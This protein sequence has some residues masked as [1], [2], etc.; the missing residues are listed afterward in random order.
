MKSEQIEQASLKLR[1]RRMPGWYW[2]Q[3]ELIDGWAPIIG[4]FA[5]GVYHVLARHS[6]DNKVAGLSIQA[7]SS[8]LATSRDSVFRAL[9]VMETH[10]LLARRSKRGGKN[11]YFLL[12]LKSLRTP[13]RRHRFSERERSPL[14][15]APIG[16]TDERT[17]AGS[18]WQTALVAGNDST[19]L[20]EQRPY[21]ESNT[22]NCK[23]T[24]HPYPSP[25]EGRGAQKSPQ[26]QDLE[27]TAEPGPWAE[28]KLCL[29]SDLATSEMGL[30]STGRAARPGWE[31]GAYD[32]YFRDSWLERI[33][34]NMLY[35][36]APNPALLEEGILKFG[37]R[38]HSILYQVLGAE[39]QMKVA[40]GVVP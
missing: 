13:A 32:R 8:A 33:E 6:R 35:L 4:I 38:L 31:T 16:F 39:V 11:V 40:K 26:I 12:D 1:D 30:G 9:A 7:I 27:P 29:K 17:R 34:G 14:A 18:P 2:S 3:N 37:K 28:V 15:I 20:G 24:P 5:V 22:Q 36:G 21:K 10:G 25:Q 23:T 19:H